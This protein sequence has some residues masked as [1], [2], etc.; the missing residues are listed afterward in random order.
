MD[1]DTTTFGLGQQQLQR[2]FAIGSDADLTGAGQSS[3]EA[4]SDLLAR[5]LSE[6]LPLGADQMKALPE[7][8]SRLCHTMGSLAGETII[9]LLKNSSTDISILRRIKRHGKRLSTH[10]LTEIEKQVAVAV[11]YGAIASAL[12]F[13]NQRISRLSYVKLEES[14]ERLS[15]EAWMSRDLS[16]LYQ[17]A[18]KYCRDRSS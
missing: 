1:K 3:V 14:F 9:S 11:Y 12:V 17:I 7:V 4:A 15:K 5:R 10:A 18:R 2:L 6:A 16:T 13:H 8:L